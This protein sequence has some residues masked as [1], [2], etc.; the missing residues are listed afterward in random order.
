M[1]EELMIESSNELEIESKIVEH[2]GII[3]EELFVEFEKFAY[4]CNESN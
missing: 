4:I 1:N 3:N 2:Y